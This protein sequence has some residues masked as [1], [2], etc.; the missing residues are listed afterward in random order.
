ME[1][2]K[3]QCSND[4]DDSE[5]IRKSRT[6]GFLASY[7][8]CGVSIGFTEVTKAEGM[9]SVTRHLLRS[10]IHGCEMPESLLYDCCCTLKLHWNKWLGTDMLKLTDITQQLPK[11]MAIHQ[12]THK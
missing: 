5:E 6:F 12:R 4:R 11:Y 3:T 10:I 1:E 9:R 2:H 8:P 7:H